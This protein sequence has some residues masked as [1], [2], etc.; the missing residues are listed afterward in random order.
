MP[1]QSTVAIRAEVGP[2]RVE[3]LTSALNGAARDSE[4]LPFRS[5]N[6]VH[7]AR[8]F[9]MPEAT[10]LQGNP[11]PACLI[12]TADVD[13]SQSRH[14]R[15]L[16]RS[17]GT[18]LD[19][20]FGY[21]DDYPAEPDFGSR[22]VW[23]TAHR[24]PTAAAYVNTVGRGAQQIRDEARLAAGI[25][26][27][28]DESV[29]ELSGRQPMEIYQTVRRDILR[30]P[31]FA[32]AQRAAARP[33]LW[34]RAKDRLHLLAVPLGLLILL[35]PITVILPIWA[36]ALRLQ[37]QREPSDHRRPDADAVAELRAH[38]DQEAHNPFIA[39]GLVKEG[40]LRR[41]TTVGILQAIKYV[42]RHVFNDGN[43]AGVKTIHFGRWVYLDDRR[44]VAFLSSYDGSLESYMDD[45]I[46]KLS[47]GLNAVFSNG[48]GYPP[49]RWLFFG[50]AKH[51]Q[52]FKNYLRSHQLLTQ[53]W[54]SAYPDL[55]ARN[56]ANNAAIRR[57]VSTPLAVEQIPDWLARL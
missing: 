29:S 16:A 32:F 6:E 48:Y 35:P 44:R 42:A 37:E 39:V 34:W 45:F 24:L 50:G 4:P 36:I 18:L 20:F 12:Y 10:D 11:I 54:Y 33:P 22:L 26:A 40:T 31:Q 15:E 2:D 25:Q 7:F 53:L 3:T 14:L 56:I 28:L 30:Q 43:L 8:L 19:S 9:L 1:Y 51:E 49:T 47:W 52:D 57:G 55:T 5:W 46:D 27:Y 13:G 23:L 17:A 21:S 38:E 41:L